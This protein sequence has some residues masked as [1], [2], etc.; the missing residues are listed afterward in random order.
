MPKKTKPIDIKKF[1][2]FVAFLKTH[3]VQQIN[4]FLVLLLLLLIPQ[5][6]ALTNW[7][8]FPKNPVIRNLQVDLPPIS[9]YPVNIT[10]KKPPLLTAL[11]VMVIDVP[12]KAIMLSQQPDLQ[13]LPAS[14]TKIMTALVVLDHYKLSDVLE[15]KDDF[16]PGQ[17]M[18]LTKGEL[19]TVENLLNGLL[20]QSG[21]DAALVLA[22]NYPGGEVNFIN[23][24][25]QKAKTL[26]L[27]KTHFVNPTGVDELTHLTTTHD[28]AILAV[29][30]MKNPLFKKTVG[31]KSLTVTDVTGQK[32]HLLTNI[33]QLVGRLPGITGVK[34]GWTEQAGECLVAQMEKN[35]QEVI[36]VVLGSQDRFEETEK[37][38]DWVFTN[39]EWQNFEYR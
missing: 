38:M 16:Y 22:Q 36:S 24:M 1:K 28:L 2:S 26:N 29:E 6:Q 10:G 20:I 34:T 7:Q 39:F 19:M 13:L 31:I 25:N 30:A 27:N 8:L 18:K 37:L 5:P 3:P 15:V 33:N 32:K 23:A 11:S 4:F 35:N 14:T 21:N 12:S 9:A 17:T